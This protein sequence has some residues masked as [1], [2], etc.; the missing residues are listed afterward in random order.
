MENKITVITPSYNRAHTLPR[1]FESLQKQTY[2][3]FKWIIM[4]DGSK[5]GTSD[6]VEEFKKV[7]NFEIEYYFNPNKHKFYTVFEGIRKVDT[8]YLTVLDSDDSYPENALET[9]LGEVEAIENQDEFISVL[10]LSADDQGEVVGDKYP[11]NGFD[12][13]VLEM[14][15]KHKVRGDKNGILITK[16]YQREMDLLDT[17]AIPS[18]IYIPL[19]VFFN[20]YDAK[21]VKNRFVNKVIRIYH[22]DDEDQNS[23]SNTRWSGNNRY[24]L[25][26]GYLSFLNSYGSQLNA[27]PKALIRNIIGYHV[28]CFANNKSFTEIQKQLKHFKFLSI[29]IV[30]FSFIYFK[31]KF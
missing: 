20:F 19:S 1:A 31:I 26:L 30:P 18:G 25:M 6:L 9:L 14:R 21:G 15:Y 28:Y 23:V 27:Y 7:S 16:T 13:S 11:G 5:D 24:G 10:G 4:D 8:P 22:K 17:A 29:L 2:K 3:G 12:G